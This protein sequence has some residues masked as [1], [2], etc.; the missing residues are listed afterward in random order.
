MRVPGKNRHRNKASS[1]KAVERR[2][3]IDMQANSTVLDADEPSRPE[4]AASAMCRDQVMWKPRGR[5]ITHDGFFAR[6]IRVE[7]DDL[8]GNQPL[9]SLDVAGIG[10]RD[11]VPVAQVSLGTRHALMVHCT[12]RLGCSATHACAHALRI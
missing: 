4:G 1:I 10:R 11:G 8:A 5:C 2:L 12:C 6:I 7:F 9:L 3:A